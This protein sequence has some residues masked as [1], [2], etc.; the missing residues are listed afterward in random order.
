MS[1]YVQHQTGKL[2]LPPPH[3]LRIVS[4]VPSVT[5]LLFDLGLNDEVVG[6][7]KFCV[8]PHQW[9]K[10]KPRIGGTKTIA[11][12]K[13]KSLK[14]TLIFAN[15][16]ENIKEQVD[17]LAN[18]FPVY[19]S[20]VETVED[21]YGLIKEVGKLT[22]TEIKA[23]EMVQQIKTSFQYLSFQKTYTAL[24]LIWQKPY[25]TV[26]GDT[27]INNMLQKAGFT[28]MLTDS[29]RY[30]EI[31]IDAIKTLKPDVLM[32][33]SEPFPFKQKHINELRKIT[34]VEK[35]VLC[36]GELFS[37]YGS[38]ML[39]AAAYFVKLRES[40]FLNNETAAQV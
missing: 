37:W 16:E 23:N 14:P 2:I 17:D 35:I 25:M 38:R 30:P 1:M 15:K 8:H 31:T 20:D 9:Y 13:V 7:T 12:E 4:F 27:F 29:K 3:P 24:Y 10:S 36:D 19:V 40:L 18:F 39:H 32:L 5:E 6:I 21:A 26:G 28:N 22:G 33:S 34:G 11:I